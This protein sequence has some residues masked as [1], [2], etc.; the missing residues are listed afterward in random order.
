MTTSE[1]EIGSLLERRSESMRTKAIEPLMALYAPDV[2]YFDLVPPLRYVGAAALRDR[3]L[4]WF[5]R[6]RTDIGLDT[7]HLSVDA[8]GD[9]AA[10]HML[11]RAHGTLNDG[12]EVDYWVRTSNGCRRADGRWLIRH[13]HVSLPVDLGSGRASMDLVP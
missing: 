4:D 3:F 11:L 12:R 7:Q 8:S 2:V 9:V 10:A 1:S 13:E 5:G 6:W